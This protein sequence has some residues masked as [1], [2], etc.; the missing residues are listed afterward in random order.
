MVA[1]P[2]RSQAF[3]VAAG[4]G[5]RQAD[6]VDHRRANTAGQPHSGITRRPVTFGKPG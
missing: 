6:H 2:Y 3:A 1:V 5:E 4:P